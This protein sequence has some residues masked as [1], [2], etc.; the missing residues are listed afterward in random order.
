MA[1]PLLA[2]AGCALLVTL[3]VWGA[4]PLLSAFADGSNVDIRPF[5]GTGAIGIALALGG[6]ALAF[7]ALFGISVR[8]HDRRVATLASR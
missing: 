3:F 4:V 5:Q 1:W 8:A 6:A 7:L 2:L